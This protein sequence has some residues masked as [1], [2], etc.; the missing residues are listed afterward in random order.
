MDSNIELLQREICRKHNASY[1]PPGNNLKVGIAE[2]VMEHVYPINGLRVP[3]EGGTA[4]WYI[5]AGEGEPSTD[6]DFFK[7]LHVAHLEDW[8]PEAIPYLGLP[9]GWRFLLAPGY[10][11]V[12]FDPRL[13]P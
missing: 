5:W 1:V 8:C 10:H 6:P 12:W 7:P 4:G 13:L 11:D 2:N 9:P 3:P